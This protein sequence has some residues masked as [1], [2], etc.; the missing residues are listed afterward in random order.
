MICG[1]HAPTS[2]NYKPPAESAPAAPPQ[3]QRRHNGRDAEP[4]GSPMGRDYEGGSS[5]TSPPPPAPPKPNSGYGHHH[6]SQ[7]CNGSVH[8]PNS[9]HGPSSGHG[10]RT[11]PPPPPAVNQPWEDPSPHGGHP[12]S[13]TA[14]LQPGESRYESMNLANAATRPPIQYQGSHGEYPAPGSPQ[15]EFHTELPCN[16]NGRHQQQPWQQ[17]GNRGMQQKP[18]QEEGFAG[19]LRLVA[20]DIWKTCHHDNRGFN[21]S[22]ER[23][24]QLP[25]QFAGQQHYGAQPWNGGQP[26][27]GGA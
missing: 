12:H 7:G 10:R 2:S 26:F 3:G 22:P 17:R 15:Q 4:R 11:T 19:F 14:P 13:G 16:M 18:F 23:P 1:D 5:A 6:G 25:Q 21:G 24:G 27:R 9:G 20:N 8:A